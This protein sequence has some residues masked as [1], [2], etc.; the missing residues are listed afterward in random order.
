MKYPRDAPSFASCLWDAKILV[1]VT[2]HKLP[3]NTN[4]GG[5]SQVKNTKYLTMHFW[6]DVICFYQ[7]IY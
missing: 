5:K 7:K 4:K 3:R 2:I 6:V 1:G